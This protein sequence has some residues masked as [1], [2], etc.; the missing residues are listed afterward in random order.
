[1]KK[2][3]LLSFFLFINSAYA[4]QL[5]F[6]N[7]NNFSTNTVVAGYKMGGL[8]GCV[9]NEKSKTLWAVRDDRSER[10]PARLYEFSLQTEGKINVLPVRHLLLKSEYKKY[11]EKN[12]V[13]LESI[14]L[15]DNGDFLLSSEGNIGKKHRIMPRLMEFNAQGDYVRD[16]AFPEVLLPEKKGKQTTGA[17]DNLVV[18]GLSRIPLSQNIVFINEQAALQDGLETDNDK[19][20]PVRLFLQEGNRV[21]KSYVYETESFLSILGQKVLNGSS[22]VSEV[23]ALNEKEFLVLERSFFPTL[24]KAKIRLFKTSVDGQ[25]TDVTNFPAL[26]GQ[27]YTALR[28]ELVLN[29]DDILTKLDKNNSTL[30]NIEGMCWGPTLKNGK[31]LLIFVSDNN[32]NSFQRTQFLFFEVSTL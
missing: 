28:K 6:L 16:W 18:E 14:A 26:R 30:D 29:F 23:L 8:S 5:Q 20:S 32:F 21:L 15:L 31:R 9:Y 25:S 10:A 4:L 7:D 3:F 22:G 11:F 12:D 27:K 1:M 17:R 2:Q 13:D 19:G 24:L